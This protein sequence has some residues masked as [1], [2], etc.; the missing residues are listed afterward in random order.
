MVN[1]TPSKSSYV[2]I[3][4]HRRACPGSGLVGGTGRTTSCSLPVAVGKNG[5]SGTDEGYRPRICDTASS[6]ASASLVCGSRGLVSPAD[7]E[8][9]IGR[10]PG[11]P[12]TG[13]T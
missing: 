10:V 1:Q 6:E 2:D 7:G 11:P 3:P 5:A 8:L 12:R 4:T 13:M 9:V